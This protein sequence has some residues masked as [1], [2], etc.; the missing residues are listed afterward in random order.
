MLP[1]E[2][3]PA[4]PLPALP[5]PLPALLEPAALPEPLSPAEPAAPPPGESSLLEQA[6]NPTSHAAPSVRARNLPIGCGLVIGS[7]VFKLSGPRKGE[8]D[9]A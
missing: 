7:S 6:A 3:L 8:T 1:V 2:P 5:L 4:L 9:Q